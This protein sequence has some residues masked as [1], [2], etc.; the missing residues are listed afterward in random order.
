MVKLNYLQKLKVNC[1]Q[2][3]VGDDLDMTVPHQSISPREILQNWVRNDSETEVRTPVEDWHGG[4]VHPN[5]IR[6]FEDDFEVMEYVA[7]K[8]SQ[9]VTLDNLG[10]PTPSDPKPADSDSNPSDPKPAE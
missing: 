5:S 3:V 2:V 8:T 4:D 1:P 10:D 7:E 9:A 6:E